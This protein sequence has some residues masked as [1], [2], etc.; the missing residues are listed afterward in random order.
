[1]RELIED[2][3]RPNA[4]HDAGTTPQRGCVAGPRMMRWSISHGNMGL[5]REISP[6]GL[7]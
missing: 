6:V 7:K 1:M 3:Q 4:E 2:P 5:L